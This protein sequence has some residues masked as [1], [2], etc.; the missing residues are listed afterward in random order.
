MVFVDD[1]Q[2]AY[3]LG[4]CGPSITLETACSSSLNALAIAA[5]S[6]LQVGD[7]DWVPIIHWYYHYGK[8][9]RSLSM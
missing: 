7:G 9:Y 3:F 8:T 4:T 1:V 2:V 5:S 6:L